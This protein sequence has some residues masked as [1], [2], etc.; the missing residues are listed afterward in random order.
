MSAQIALQARDYA[1]PL[2][3]ARQATIIDPEFWIGH[4]QVAN[5]HHQLGST[6]LALDALTKVRQAASGGMAMRGYFLAKL[7]RTDEARDVLR[8]M[9]AIARDRYVPPS[10]LAVVHAGL[11]DRE[12]AFEQLEKAY[13]ARDAHL[14][15]L[16]V[17]PKWDPYRS[18][19]RFGELLARCGFTRNE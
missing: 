15:F 8:A 7:G 4:V 18:D 16:P 19:P 3:H 6:E 17:D 2:E 12:A 14:I 9:E 1:A 10:Q 13:E 5:A 11:G